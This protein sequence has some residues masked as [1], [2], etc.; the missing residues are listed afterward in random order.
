MCNKGRTERSQNFPTEENDQRNDNVKQ[1]YTLNTH[2]IK[3]DTESDPHAN[4][5]KLRTSQWDT[6]MFYQWLEYCMHNIVTYIACY[7]TKGFPNKAN[8][9]R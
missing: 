8:S 3:R 2:R 6:N 1:N 9:R 7:N 5:N 4:T